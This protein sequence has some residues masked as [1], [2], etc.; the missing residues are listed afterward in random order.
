MPRQVKDVAGAKFYLCQGC[1]EWKR[2]AAFSKDESEVD[3]I[4]GRCKECNK[5]Y[6]EKHKDHRGMPFYLRD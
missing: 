4:Q 3:G 2:K 1:R 6:W 5:R